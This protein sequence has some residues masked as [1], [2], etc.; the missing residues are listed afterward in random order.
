MTSSRL[1]I[2]L[3]VGGVA[4]LTLMALVNA[5]SP[6]PTF[7]KLDDRVTRYSHNHADPDDLNKPLAQ[8]AVQLLNAYRLLFGGSGFEIYQLLNIAFYAAFWPS[9]MI[10]MT[11]WALKP[12]RDN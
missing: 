11:F 1:S 6:E 3:F 2:L 7:E 5:V 10:A 9:L 8:V 4:L 12:V